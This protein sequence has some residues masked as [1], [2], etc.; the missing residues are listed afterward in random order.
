[1]ITKEKL[2]NLTAWAIYIWLKEDGEEEQ[3]AIETAYCLAKR[4]GNLHLLN[5][6][7]ME[8]CP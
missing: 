3:K 7:G 2:S 6:K 1:M 8:R 4:L 5:A